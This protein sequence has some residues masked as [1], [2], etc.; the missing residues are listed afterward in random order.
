MNIPYVFRAGTTA[1]SAEVNTNFTEVKKAIDSLEENEAIVQS[2]LDNKANINGDPGELFNVAQPINPNNAVTLAF[3]AQ[4]IRVASNIIAGAKITP[5]I[6]GSTVI[7]ITGG[8]ALNDYRNGGDTTILTAA[9]QLDIAP[10]E[11]GKEYYIFMTQEPGDSGIYQINASK[12]A[13]FPGAYKLVGSFTKATAT[14][15]SSLAMIGTR[16]NAE[17]VVNVL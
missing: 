10:Y 9:A 1:K 4:A 6:E 14:T 16:V 17:E 5:P 7:D 2:T 13:I 3:L 15:L 11:V 12:Y 8:T